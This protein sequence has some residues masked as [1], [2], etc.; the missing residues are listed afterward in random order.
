MYEAYKLDL[1][2]PQDH[3]MSLAALSLE[4]SMLR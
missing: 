3:F 2:R 4:A 1:I